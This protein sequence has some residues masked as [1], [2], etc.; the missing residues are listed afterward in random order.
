MG[1]FNFPKLLKNVFN[2]TNLYRLPRKLKKNY[3]ELNHKII[4][5][6]IKL[7][8]LTEYIFQ[9]KKLVNN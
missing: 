3:E 9:I 4:I 7:H 1:F 2:R 8:E 5:Y 6:I